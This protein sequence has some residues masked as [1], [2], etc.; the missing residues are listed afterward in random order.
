ML[1]HIFWERINIDAGIAVLFCFVFLSV[2]IQFSYLVASNSL[3]SHGLQHA[4]PPHP[5]TTPGVYTNSCPLSQWCHLI[6]S[7]SVFPFSSCLQSFPASGSFSMNQFLASGGQ[8]SGVAALASVLEYSRLISFRMDWLGLL[9]VQET[10]KSL[11]KHHSSKTSILQHSAFFIFQLSHPYMTKGVSIAL[12]RWTFV[13][14]VT[15]LLF[16]MLSR[17]VI[18]S[19]PSF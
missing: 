2:R 17:L 10:L 1:V 12:T 14:K 16:N 15:C 11:L 5:S 3:W 4:R 19:L 18:V 8:S 6:I 7:S 9:A 13:G